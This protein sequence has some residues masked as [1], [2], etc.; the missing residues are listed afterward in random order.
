MVVRE[1]AADA[2]SA[3]QQLKGYGVE[4]WFA[5]G[6][7]ELNTI[8]S[9]GMAAVVSPDGPKLLGHMVTFREWVRKNKAA[10]E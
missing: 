1:C 4:P 9:K 10:F 2:A 6:L 8:V 5:E 7:G 3:A